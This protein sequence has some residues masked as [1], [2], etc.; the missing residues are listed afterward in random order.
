MQCLGDSH[1][2]SV[3]SFF[4]PSPGDSSWNIGF[5]HSAYFPSG[6]TSSFVSLFSPA[7]SAG[8]VEL[9]DPS[10]YMFLSLFLPCPDVSHSKLFYPITSRHGFVIQQRGWLPHITQEPIT[11]RTFPLTLPNH[12]FPE[13]F[14]DCM[15]IE[16][17][18][19]LFRNVGN[20]VPIYATQPTGR[21][22][23]SAFPVFTNCKALSLA[24]LRKKNKLL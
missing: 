2:S 9:I 7:P 6:S 5:H 18:D 11:T 1:S 16:G 22:K 24:A 13:F 15:I 4:R 17:T 10:H 21:A 23:G 3:S 20:Q 12:M 8:C 14:L 19:M